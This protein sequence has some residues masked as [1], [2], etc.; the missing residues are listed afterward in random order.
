[1]HSAIRLYEC[2]AW[3]RMGVSAK[4]F[5]RKANDVRAELWRMGRNQSRGEGVGMDTFQD[6]EGSEVVKSD[7]QREGWPESFIGHIR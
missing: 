6:R 4:I 3:P 1:M 5:Q 2:G 7:E